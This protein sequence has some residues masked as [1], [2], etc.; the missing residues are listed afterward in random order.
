MTFTAIYVDPAIDIET[1]PGA[2]ALAAVAAERGVGIVREPP[3]ELAAAAAL[4][5]GL[6]AADAAVGLG[7]AQVAA[8]AAVGD[9]ASI[10][11]EILVAADPAEL[12]LD[13]S[14][15]LALKTLLGLP[16]ALERV[17]EIGER[18]GE[19]RLA[20]FLD[21][22]GT[23]SEIVENPADARLAPSMRAAVAALAQT[24]A[25]AIV[26]GRDLEDVRAL[27]GLDGLH[28][29]GSHGFVM[30]GPGGWRETAPE[31]APFPPILDA[32]EAALRA[33]LADA[34]GVSVERKSF[35]LAVHHRRAGSEAAGR[36]EN[37]LARLLELEPRLASSA[38]K[39]V[40]DVKPRVDWDKGR[41]TL[42]L[43]RRF[44]DVAAMY[45][46]D[47]TTDE[48]A[49]RI[50]A[51]DGVTIVARDGG[52]RTTA[53]DYALDGVSAVEEFLRRLSGRS[54]GA[55]TPR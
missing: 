22:D 4:V 26:S 18:L 32:A 8:I 46:G 42:A 36:I 39:K 54:G 35:S 3:R 19:A 47:D 37:A 14:G 40:F 20:V 30:A 7:Y 9:R 16:S 1:S 10:A 53:A 25:V 12:H 34:P 5:A 51:G 44:G 38:G 41:A 45:I 27:V 11:G 2:R 49:F 50:L 52:D 15:R 43:M 23:L 28:Y 31:G 17:D 48:D 6:D 29:A 33:A 21:Y 55:P 13:A 24:C